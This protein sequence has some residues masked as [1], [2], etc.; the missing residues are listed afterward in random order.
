VLPWITQFLERAALLRALRRDILAAAIA[1]FE[2]R[3]D[4]GKFLI[5]PASEMGGRIPIEV[6][7]SPGGARE[8]LRCIARIQHRVVL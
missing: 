4:A 6:A 2:T 7:V 5:C 1:C 8:V 3:E